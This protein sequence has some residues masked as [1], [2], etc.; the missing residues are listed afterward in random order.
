MPMPVDLTVTYEDGTKE[1]YNIALR[2][3]RGNKTMP[4]RGGEMKVLED[5]PWTHPEYELNIPA[6]SK[7]IKSIEIDPSERMAD[8]DR[9]N[10]TY[11]VD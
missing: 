7:K 4:T 8:I 6:T 5:W 11:V 10:N 3:M 9:A 1:V 2:I